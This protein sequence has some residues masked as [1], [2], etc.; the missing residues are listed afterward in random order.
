MTG[1]AMDTIIPVCNK[2][3]LGDPEEPIEVPGAD[4][5]TQSH[6]HWQFVGVWQ[7]LVKNHPGVRRVKE[8]TSAV[9][10]QSG[11]D[12]EWWADSMACCCYLRNIQDLFCLMAKSPYESWFGV[13]FNVPVIPFGAMVEYYLVS[14]KDVSR[15][16]QFGPKVLS[17]VFLGCSLHAWKIWKGD[18]LDAD[19]EELEP[20]GSMQREW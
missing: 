1:H 19:I 4:E 6:L 12:N 10:L 17:G 9:L 15:Q 16:H 20:E 5:E 13:P 2:N 11:L 18:I 7:N 14:A 3:F 8:G